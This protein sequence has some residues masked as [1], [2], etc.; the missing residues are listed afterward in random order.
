M[1]QGRSERIKR[2]FEATLK[3]EFSRRAGFLDS[4]CQ[5]EPE[6]RP[7]LERLLAA[8]SDATEPSALEIAHVLF[9]DIVKYSMLPMDQQAELV[10]QLQH[11]VRSTVEYNHANTREELISLPTGDGMALVFLRNPTA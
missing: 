9:M 8:A 5:G 2:L 7:E 6:L 11:V 1:T 4:A 3:I 10:N